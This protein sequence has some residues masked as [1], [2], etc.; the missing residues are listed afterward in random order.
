LKYLVCLLLLIVTCVNSYSKPTYA[1]RGVLDLRQYDFND[2]GVKLEGEWEFYMSQL[3]EPDAIHASAQTTDYLQ[4]PATWNDLS[5]SRRPGE[6]Y[7][8][9][10]LRVFVTSPESLAIELPHMYSNYK[11]WINN[12]LIA[13]NGTVGNSPESSIPQWLPQ[14]VPYHAES[15]TLDFVLQIS[16]FHHAKGGIREDITL[17]KEKSMMSKRA[18]SVTSNLALIISIVILA[19]TF[20]LIYFIVKQDRASLYFAALC[21]TWA[22]RAGFSNLYV[23]TSFFPDFPWELAVKVEYVALYLT[24]ICAV[25]FISSVFPHDV[26]QMFKYLFIACNII[27]AGITVFLSPSLF[28]QFLPVYLSFAAILLLYIIYVLVHAIV[29]ERNGVWFIVS[30]FMVGV[31]VFAYDIISYQAFAHFN[32]VLINTGYVAMF[33]LLALGLTFKLELIKAGGGRQN[34][35]TYEDLYGP[36]K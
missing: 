20:I 7:A 2:G 6:G 27:F 36:Q 5:E 35:L 17:G 34:M 14:T 22:V 11:L 10:H 8:T 4:F 33:I 3:L 21:L 25:S 12:Q 32:S 9:Y 13:Y 24:M 30:C 1:R 26:S 28:T 29:Y 16:N 23:V 18:I 31:I 19:I 15:D